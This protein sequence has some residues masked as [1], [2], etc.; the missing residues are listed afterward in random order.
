MSSKETINV[1]VELGTRLWWQQEA[2]KNGFIYGNGGATGE[3][4]DAI[5]QGEYVIIKREAWQQL[6]SKTA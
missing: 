4:L 1:R 3:F 2:V 5:A 6:F